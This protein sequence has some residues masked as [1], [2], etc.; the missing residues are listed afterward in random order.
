MDRE[1]CAHDVLRLMSPGRFHICVWETETQCIT[2][3]RYSGQRTFWKSLLAA[4]YTMWKHGKLT[5]ENFHQ[6]ICVRDTAT[7]KM[8]KRSCVSYTG[9][10]TFIS[11]FPQKSPIISGSFVKNDS[12]LLR[13]TYLQLCS[14]AR[15]FCG[16]VGLFCGNAGLFCSAT[17]ASFWLT[18]PEKL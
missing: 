10:H 15:L 7:Y 6:T 18:S 13:L 14:N 11:H 3:H 9:I 4:I 5:F 8:C 2:C 17:A 16:N 1:M 12:W